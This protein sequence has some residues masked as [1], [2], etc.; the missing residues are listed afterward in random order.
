[1]IIR[2]TENSKLIA[3][4]SHRITWIPF[5]MIDFL[6]KGIS[7]LVDTACFK[8]TLRNMHMKG[9]KVINTGKAGGLTFS[10]II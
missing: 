8:K 10:R 2:G 9:F 6:P 1:M 7:E 3:K 5:N 4:P